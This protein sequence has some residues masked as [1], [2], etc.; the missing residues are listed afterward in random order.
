MTDDIYEKALIQLAH[1]R[2]RINK[3]K[4]MNN[5]DKQAALLEHAARKMREFP[6]SWWT[7][8]E[9]YND[10]KEYWAPLYNERLFYTALSNDYPA[11][12]RKQA[13]AWRQG[14]NENTAWQLVPVKP[15]WHMLDDGWR[16]DGIDHARLERAYGAMLARAADPGDDDDR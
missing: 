15:T 13:E 7:A 10:D 12:R 4:H 14:H 5:I 16:M 3:E 2:R 11:I 6:Q 9:Y 1:Y 8:F